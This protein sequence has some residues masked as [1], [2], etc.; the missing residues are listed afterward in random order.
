MTVATL[1]LSA[2]A[3]AVTFV[4]AGAALRSRAR[5]R[6]AQDAPARWLETITRESVI[7][8]LD[9]DRSI[10]GVIAGVHADVIVLSHAR[11]EDGLDVV[12]LKGEIAIPLARVQW[13]QR[14]ATLN[15]VRSIAPARAAS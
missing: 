4:V 11:F 1:V 14:G 9:D 15:D 5:A 8:Q 13:A 12:P 2:L 10:A 7:L 6:A 3:L